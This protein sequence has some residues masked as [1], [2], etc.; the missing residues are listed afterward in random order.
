MSNKP[1]NYYNSYFN[2]FFM[3][4][5]SNSHSYVIADIKPAYALL[6]ESMQVDDKYLLDFIKGES[7]NIFIKGESFNK[8]YGEAKKLL[9]VY[10]KD[11]ISKSKLVDFSKAPLLVIT[12]VYKKTKYV[13]KGE[14]VLRVIND[15]INNN[16]MLGGL[17]YTEFKQ[18][19]ESNTPY[20]KDSLIE[21]Q[22]TIINLSGKNPISEY[23]FLLDRYETYDTSF[24]DRMKVASDVFI[25]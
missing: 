13:I 9:D 24:I 19:I 11:V 15:F 2:D 25:F 6:L 3:Y 10:V 14:F 16:I 8:H 22:E 20:W 18:F 17:T 1:L 7:F 21:M 4:E 23:L 12:A 5:S